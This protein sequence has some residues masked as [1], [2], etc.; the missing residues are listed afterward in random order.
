MAAV[1]QVDFEGRARL[2]GFHGCA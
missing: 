2:L 1:H